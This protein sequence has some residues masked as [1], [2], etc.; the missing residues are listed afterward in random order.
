[1]LISITGCAPEE[2]WKRATLLSVLVTANDNIYPNCFRA[3]AERMVLPLLEYQLGWHNYVSAVILREHSSCPI[4]LLP[5]KPSAR[6]MIETL[7]EDWGPNCLGRN[8]WIDCWKFRARAALSDG[9]YVVVSDA[10][11]EQEVAAM[12]DICEHPI[13][14]GADDQRY[15]EG[16]SYF[17]H[18]EHGEPIHVNAGRTG[19]DL[20][21]AEL[22]DLFADYSL[23]LS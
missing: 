21:A 4:D 9:K 7:H 11:S 14:I 16:F 23:K 12:H 10:D 5:G 19:F 1:M 13:V 22:R 3:L 18:D 6:H 8:F 20:L 2:Y 15:K 17:P